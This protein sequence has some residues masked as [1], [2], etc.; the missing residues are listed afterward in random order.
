MAVSLEIAIAEK[1]FGAAAPVFESFELSVASGEVVALIGPS[2]VGK[3]TLLRLVAGV[4]HAFGGTITIDDEAA[5]DAPP[6]GFV[7]QDARLLPWLS[8]RDNVRLAQPQMDDATADRHLAAVGLADR[9]TAWPR[10]LSGGMQR[11]VALAR[12]LATNARLLLLDEPFVS[13]DREL[14]GEMQA[15]LGTVLAARRPTVLLVTHM[16]EDAATLADRAVILDGRPARIVRQVALPQPR[17]E[18]QPADIAAYAAE[19]AA[20]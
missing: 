9:A 7:F 14:A 15:L 8:A 17:A 19:I 13:L 3:S 18:R 2:G 4:D 16:A 20:N 5:S 6:P 12:A 10:E 11:R 1:R